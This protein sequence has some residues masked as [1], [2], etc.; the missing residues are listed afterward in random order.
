MKKNLRMSEIRLKFFFFVIFILGFSLIIRLGYLQVVRGKEL[1]KRAL[2]QW[3]KSVDIKSERGIIYD[4][5]GKKLAINING[6]SVWAFPER[7]KDAH[8]TALKLAELLY[9]DEELV[10]EKITA[11]KNNIKLKQWIN[12][13]EAE[14]LVE[15]GLSGIQLQDE[16]KRVYPNGN[17]ASHILGFTDIDNN[18]L[19]GVEKTFDKYLNGIPGKWYKMTDGHNMQL[20]YGGERIHEAENG[21]SLVLTIDETIQSIAEKAAQDA[22]DETQAKN[23]TA[24]V[25]DPNTGEI[26]AMVNKPDF[27]PNKPREP[28]SEEEKEEWLKLSDEELQQKWY[29]QWRNVAVNDVYEPGSTFKL[30]VAAAALE[31][32]V[33]NENYGYVCNGAITDIPGRV[34]R[35]AAVYPHGKIDFRFGVAD[36][37]NVVFVN[38]G[39]QL[40]KKKIYEYTKAFG[41]GEKTYVDLLGEELGL[42]PIGGENMQDVSLATLSYGHGIAVTPIQLI[43]SVNAIVNGGKLLKPKIVKEIIN[44]NNELVKEI[45]TE[46]RRQVISDNTSKRMLNLMEAVVSEGSGKRARIPGYRIGGKTGT[47]KKI[48][49]GVYRDGKYIASFI[50]VAPIE[51]PQFVTLVIVDEP[52]QGKHYGGTAAAPAVKQIFENIFT[53]KDIQPTVAEKGVEKDELVEVPNVVGMKMEEAGK[54][55]SDL[56]LKYVI[57]NV[58]SIDNVVISQYPEAWNYLNRGDIIDLNVEKLDADTKVIPNFIGEKR[59]ETIKKLKELNVKYSI[60]GTMDRVKEQS[61]SPGTKIE[62]E[63]EIII[64]CTK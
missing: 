63:T 61:L 48:I 54:V 21:L 46:V 59:D 33:T 18:G 30:V 53:Y 24:I 6:Y 11:D 25:M 1:E 39:R 16:N 45:P 47:A 42:L 34:L 43:N 49:D 4:R 19:D 2:E 9:M 62:A 50:G 58:E 7:I 5:T 26:L 14:K 17:F 3:S 23:V 8:Q 44:E 22:M 36:S 27:D 41:F 56:G 10:Y 35:C 28:I 12:I 51:N 60:E 64:K 55:L 37:C 57:N 29:D 38:V 52:V 13:E 40:G 15:L 31:E 32:N 20:P